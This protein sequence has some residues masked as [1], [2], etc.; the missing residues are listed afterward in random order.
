MSGLF[1]KQVNA[2]KDIEKLMGFIQGPANPQKNCAM[3]IKQR[4]NTSIK[5]LLMLYRAHM[6]NR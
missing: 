5:M 3:K 1:D 6:K 4:N 2:Q